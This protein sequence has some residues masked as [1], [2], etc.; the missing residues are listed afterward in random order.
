MF[1]PPMF[2]GRPAFGWTEIGIGVSVFSCSSASSIVFGP[3]EQFIPMAS[4]PNGVIAATKLSSVVPLSRFPS[5]FIVTWATN[6]KSGDSS[7]SARTAWISSGTRE[8]VSKTT[9]STPPSR[10]PRI[11]SLKA[12]FASSNDSFPSG[13]IWT[14]SGPTD[15]ATSTVSP[16]AFL[17]ICAPERF[18]SWTFGSSP[19]AASLNRVAPN[20]FVSMM[21]A[22]AFT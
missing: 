20:V 14:P 8:K 18:T 7:F 22:P 10:S 17:A 2:C 1:R 9:R 13:S 3:T 19:C 5:S 6:G 16:A 12:S 11:A 21:S 4:G 15:P